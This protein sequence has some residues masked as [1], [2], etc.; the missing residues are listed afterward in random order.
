MARTFDARPDRLDLT[1]LPDRAPLRSLPPRHPLDADV[2]KYISSYVG[3][4]LIPNQGTEGTCTGFGLACISKLPV[5]DSPPATRTCACRV[6]ASQP[7]HV[8]SAPHSRRDCQ[9]T[10]A[11]RRVDGKGKTHA[12]T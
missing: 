11:H 8:P 7:A 3:A 9:E 1:D 10:T 2:V 5:L 12:T 4:G 6:I